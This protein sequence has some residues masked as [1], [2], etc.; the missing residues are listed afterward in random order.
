[1]D[2]FKPWRAVIWTAL[3]STSTGCGGVPGEKTATSGGEANVVAAAYAAPTAPPALSPTLADARVKLAGSPLLSARPAPSALF[4]AAYQRTEADWSQVLFLCDGVD[5]DRVKL[6]T[7][8]DAK[9]LSSMW[10]YAKPDFRTRREMVRVGNQDAGAGSVGWPLLD[11]ADR[12]I[13]SVRSFNPQMLGES[14]AAGLPSLR[15]IRVQGEV[16][17]CRWLEKA[18]VMLVTSAR[19]VVVTRGRAGY[20]YT[21]FDYAKNGRVIQRSASVSSKPTLSIGGGRLLLTRQNQERYEFPNG[22]WTYRIDASADNRAPGALLTV[23]KDGQIVQTSTAS[24]YQ[25]SARRIE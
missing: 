20:R 19:T 25:L 24:A 21:S 14:D 22:P 23:L 7:T 3:L 17:R 12:E 4:N 6:I 5:G 1:V 8:P 2:K 15:S 9:G 18:R 13:G 16:T 10:T 11:R